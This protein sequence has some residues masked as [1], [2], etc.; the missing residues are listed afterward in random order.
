MKLHG[1]AR[2]CPNSRRL[3]IERVI[4]EGWSVSGAAAAAGISERSVYRCVD[5]A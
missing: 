1:N 2:T 5:A 4:E 3:L